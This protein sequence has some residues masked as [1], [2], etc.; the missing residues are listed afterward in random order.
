[1]YAIRSYYEVR[2]V[3]GGGE[4]DQEGRVEFRATYREKGVPRAHHEVGHFSRVEG[5]VITSY[6]IHYTKLYEDASD[7]EK[8]DVN[9][10]KSPSKKIDFKSNKWTYYFLDQEEI[11]FLENIAT[12]RKV[13]TIGKY[14]N[15]EVVITSY[16][17]HYTKL[18]DVW[19]TNGA[20]N[21]GSPLW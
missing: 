7:L 20:A 6:S 11:D 18:Y 21:A 19:H 12:K 9:I 8:L 15:V 4:A 1:M 2:H 17:I 14:A 16:S 5:R 3:E 10:L 13:P